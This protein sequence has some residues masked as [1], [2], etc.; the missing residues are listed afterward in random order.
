MIAF[1]KDLSQE[2]NLMSIDTGM[3]G[4]IFSGQYF[5]MNQP[6]LVGEL[7]NVSTNFDILEK[8]LGSYVL[9]I[10]PKKGSE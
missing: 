7:N 5:T 3:S 2:V 10:L 6:H 4:N 8:T 9:N 1:E